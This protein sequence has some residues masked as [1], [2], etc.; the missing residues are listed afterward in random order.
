MLFIAITAEF[1]VD[2]L[3]SLISTLDLTNGEQLESAFKLVL[4]PLQKIFW[5]NLIALALSAL[6]NVVV[7]NKLKNCYQGRF[8]IIRSFMATFSS[9]LVYIVV[10]YTLWFWGKMPVATLI[11]MMIVSMS[12]KIIFAMVLAYPAQLITKKIITSHG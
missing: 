3:L 2:T 10:A 4:S 1:Y 5:G 12:F 8:F 6:M 9:E 7:M 11:S